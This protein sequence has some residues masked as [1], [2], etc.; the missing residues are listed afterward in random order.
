MAQR[1]GVSKAAASKVL[2]GVVD[3]SA[4]PETRLRIMEAAE[5]LGYR[6]HVAARALATSNARTVA[7]LV[8]RLTD[9][10]AVAIARGAFER[11]AERGYVAVMSEDFDEQSAMTAF[12]DLV[13]AGR[14]DGLIVASSRPDHKLIAALAESA[15]PHV[16]LNRAVPGTGRNVVMDVAESSRLALRHLADLGHRTVAHIA[17]PPGITPSDDRARAFAES[18]LLHGL[19]VCRIEH[20][21]LTEAGGATAAATIIEAGQATAVY[22]S[23]LAQAIGAIHA[24]HQAGLVIPDDLSLIGDEDFPIAAYLTPALTT[25]AMP[26]GEL[27]RY[28]ADAIIDQLE[29]AAPGDVVIPTEPR[30]VVRGSTGPPDLL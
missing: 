26:L 20:A 16:F 4:R 19:T 18:A 1:A 11:A 2:N 5:A 14:V 15:I 6:P 21:D 24:A 29:G 13:H 23:S 28:G 7:L 30:L 10:T 22:A 9:L 3:F 17:G 27:G 25:I 12:R 8:P